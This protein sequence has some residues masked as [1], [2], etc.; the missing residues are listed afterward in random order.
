VNNLNKNQ[1]TTFKNLKGKTEKA[2][3]TNTSMNQSRRENLGSN[4]DQFP[5]YLKKSRR[6][7]E[8]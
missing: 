8:E 6:K 3:G 2:N 1:K 4:L 7:E 5:V